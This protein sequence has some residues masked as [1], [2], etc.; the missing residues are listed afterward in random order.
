[1]YKLNFVQSVHLR[2]IAN[3]KHDTKAVHEFIVD[4]WSEWFP[5]LPKYESYVK[6]VNNLSPAFRVLTQLLMNE[7]ELDATVLEHIIDSLP[8]MVAN[9]RRSGSAK[10][11]PEMCDKGY[12]S[13]K[14]MWYYGV[15]LH[16]LSQKQY[17]SLPKPA[18]F[19]LTPASVSDITFAKENLCD[20][21]NIDVYGDKIYNDSDWFEYMRD[22]YNVNLVAPVKLKKGQ[23]VLESI[24]RLYNSAVSSIR[25]PIESFFNWIIEKTHIQSASKVRSSNGL[26]SFVF[27]RLAVCFLF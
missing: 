26:L 11:A 12:C 23:E 6:R 17:R 22:Y 27:A 13:S 10:V 20:F 19:G 18:M 25:Q 16:S 24:D 9:S 21:R 2:G 14:N 5:A 4:Y 15:K 3:E 8:I 7:Q 1:M